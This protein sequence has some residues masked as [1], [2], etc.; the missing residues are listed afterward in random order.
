M[1]TELSQRLD[2]VYEP[3]MNGTVQFRAATLLFPEYRISLLILWH[4]LLAGHVK[5]KASEEQ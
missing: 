2:P 4:Y 3:R 5:G 1:I